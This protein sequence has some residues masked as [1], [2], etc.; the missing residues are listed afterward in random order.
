MLIEIVTHCWAER[1]PQYAEA[2]KY[3]LSSLALFPPKSCQVTSTVCYV[4][5]DKAT[6]EVLRQLDPHLKLKRR[7]KMRDAPHLGRRSIGRNYAALE[8][9]A[10]LIWFSD[11]DQLFWEGCLDQLATLS[12]P[13]KATMIYP[14]T[15]RISGNH[16]VGD[17]TLAVGKSYKGLRM[18]DPS[19]FVSKVYYRAIGGVQI[20]QGDFARQYGYLNGSKKYQRPNPHPFGDFRDDITY[21]QT[22]L[23]T[24]AIVAVDLPGLFR[25]RH[26]CATYV[27]RRG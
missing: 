13:T 1:F 24:G 17:Q 7:I 11:V 27:R 15:I 4:E 16:A 9:E 21:R 5:S 22:C 8:T 26:S 6:G 25:I 10:D 2:L 12:W 23:S 18:I 3:H 14:R 19:D 20:V